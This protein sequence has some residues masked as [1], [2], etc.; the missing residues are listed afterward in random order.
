MANKKVSYIQLLKEAITEFDSKAMDYKGPLTDTILTFDGNGELETCKDASSILE[1][2]Y[3]NENKEKLIEQDVGPDNP[4][5]IDDDADAEDPNEIITGEEPDDVDETMED[6]E[7]ELM[8]EDLELED[9][10]P[11]DPDIVAKDE[12]LPEEKAAPVNN[13]SEIVNLENIVIE[14]LIR[15]MEE[16]ETQQ[17]GTDL[18]SEKEVESKVGKDEVKDQI[19]E[20]IDLLEAELNAELGEEDKEDEDEKKDEEDL[21]VDKKIEAEGEGMGPIRI[22]A[23]RE[24][25]EAFKL[26]QE[27]IEEE[28]DEDEEEEEDEKKELEEQ[29]DLDEQ[30]ELKESLEIDF[31]D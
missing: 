22:K 15:E 6:L 29:D 24:I 28:E 21:N 26:F 11:G 17:A 16:E 4:V 5:D 1:R 12:P 30:D 7:D 3:F 31:E 23:A 25:E 27:Q 20:D 9:Y 2:Y 13:E 18:A 14:K 19:E 10:E 8:E